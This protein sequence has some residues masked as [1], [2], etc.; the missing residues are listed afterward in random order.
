MVLLALI[1]HNWTTVP[2]AL[3]DA[4]ITDIWVLRLVTVFS[5]WTYCCILSPGVCTY[6][7]VR[8]KAAQPVYL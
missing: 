4:A 7:A 8:V 1:A 5:L 2:S 6:L 3:G